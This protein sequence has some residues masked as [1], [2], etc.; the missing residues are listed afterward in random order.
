MS[1]LVYFSSVSENTHRFVEK[2]EMPAIR[3]PLRERIE[4][5]QPYVL[6]LPTYGGGHANGPDPM[7][8]DTSPNRSSHSSTTSTTGR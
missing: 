6:V 3:I 4:V 5:D 7:P 8:G 2:L 1:N